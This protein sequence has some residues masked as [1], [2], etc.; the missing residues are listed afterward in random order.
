MNSG[1]LSEEEKGKLSQEMEELKTQINNKIQEFHLEIESDRRKTIDKLIEEL[2]EKVSSFGE[3]RGYS[4]I[5]D[6]NELIFSDTSLD[7]TKEIVDYINEGV[8]ANPQKPANSEKSTVP[9]QRGT[10]TQKKGHG[11]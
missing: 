6:R 9:E 5:L 11:K 3:E 2:R 10:G 4:M 8:S 7:L 1:V